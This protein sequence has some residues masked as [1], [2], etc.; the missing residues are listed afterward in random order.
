[1]L[2]EGP[3]RLRGGRV[4]TE[5]QI[6][7]GTLALGSYLEAG[8]GTKENFACV[9]GSD[10]TMQPIRTNALDS[11][12]SPTT[13]N[14]TTSLPSQT[15]MPLIPTHINT[16]RRRKS[17]KGS[18]GAIIKRS[19]STPNVRGLASGE[20]AMSLAEKRRNKLGYHRTS[21]ACGK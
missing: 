21:V 19:V 12:S 6:R 16:G 20:V 7:T 3:T 4:Q 11:R 17:S 8:P 9:V 15:D 14:N 10:F 13:L 5:T 2:V 18:L 1:M